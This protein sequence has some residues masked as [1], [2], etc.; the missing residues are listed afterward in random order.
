MSDNMKR[1]IVRGSHVNAEKKLL[2]RQ[3]RHDQTPAEDHLWQLLRRNQL[4]RFHFR[5]QQVIDGFIVDFYCHKAGLVV[6]LDGDI[7]LTQKQADH[8]REKVLQ[9]RG[10]TVIRF[11]N[12]EVLGNTSSVLQEICKECRKLT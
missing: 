1:N 8:E 2:S 10:L 3:L 11:T 4:G 12:D 6:E 5:R 9:E 7:H